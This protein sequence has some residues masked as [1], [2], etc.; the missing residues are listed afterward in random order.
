MAKVI[1]VFQQ[2]SLLIWCCLI[3][4][5][6]YLCSIKRNEGFYDEKSSVNSIY[7]KHESFVK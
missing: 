5:N 1:F 3:I 7:L 2:K 6:Y 4:I